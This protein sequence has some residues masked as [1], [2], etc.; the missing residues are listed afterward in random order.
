[1]DTAL[2][3]RQFEDQAKACDALGSP[4]T[5]RLLR[6]LA[7]K[8]DRSSTFG[9]A[10]LEWPTDPYGDNIALRVAGALHALARSGRAPDLSAVYPPAPATVDELWSP[11][12]RA[13][14]QHGTD[15]IA[16]LASAPQ[17]NEVARSGLLLGA[18]LTLSRRFRLPLALYEIGASAG[19]NLAFDKYRYRLG[20]NRV[21]GAADAPLTIDCEWRGARPPLDTALEIASRQ[22]CDLRPIDPANRAD[23][24]RLMSY[25]WP[26]QTQRLQRTQAALKLAADE[27][28]R[29]SGA[30]AAEWVEAEFAS[31]HPEGVARVLYHTIVWQ[32][33]PKETKGRIESTL[34]RATAAATETRP[35]A[36]FSFEQDATPGSG[37]MLLTLWPSRETIN[38]GRGDFHGR[39]AEW[40]QASP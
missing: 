28:R 16:G 40:A 22:G 7:L 9:R 25:I 5:A 6:L 30:D 33:L 19:L 29:I 26:D 32:Y 23:T 18:M 36:R 39:W 14:A 35:V 3:L 1:M 8:L 37:A 20:E 2:V 21:W 10:V 27:Q 24:E 12:S 31:P 13:L 17:T 38:L 11:L 34:A 15:L 4:F